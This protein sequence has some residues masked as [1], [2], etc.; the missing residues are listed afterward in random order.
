MK[1]GAILWLCATAGCFGANLDDPPEGELTQEFQTGCDPNLPPC[2]CALKGMDICADPDGDGIPSL[3]DNCRYVYNPDQAD[4][5]G[6]GVGD[7]CD[8]LN[9][10]VTTTVAHSLQ[11]PQVSSYSVCVG[12]TEEPGTLY[13][14]V[15]QS[16]RVT[17]T[18]TRTRCGPSGSGS[19][20]T[21]ETT[22]VLVMSCY[23]TGARP[24]RCN[25]STSQAVGPICV[26]HNY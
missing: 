23:D 10:I 21:V 3:Y 22:D 5:D 1:R 6:D 26:G 9:E 11:P 15:E 8:S 17:T 12:D 7:A 18:T 25:Y 14:I 4:C 24:R 16:D 19:D 20:T 2:A 13:R